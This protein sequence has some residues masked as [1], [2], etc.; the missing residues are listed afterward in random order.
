MKSK[1]ETTI[2]YAPFRQRP[3]GTWHK[4]QPFA[5]P[6]R[7]SAERYIDMYKQSPRYQPGEKFKIMRR[8]V[9][10]TKTEWQDDFV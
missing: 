1:T 4:I 8:S 9:T 3:D 6:S 7:A 5:S 2:Q 10:L